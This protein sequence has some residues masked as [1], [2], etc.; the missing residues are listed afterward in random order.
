MWNINK[1]GDCT[2]AAQPWPLH[3][4]KTLLNRG[5]VLKKLRGRRRLR[6][7]DVFWNRLTPEW[8]KQKPC[9]DSWTCPNVV[10]WWNSQADWGVKLTAAYRML[11]FNATW[12]TQLHASQCELSSLISSYVMQQSCNWDTVQKYA[13][14]PGKM[15]G[16]SIFNHFPKSC[17]GCIIL[18]KT[19]GRH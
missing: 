16:F 15:C 2:A 11:S 5:F 17:V 3:N 18:Q 4:V 14:C 1:A 6:V 7:A 13:E 19:R 8:N 12:W 10:I 9:V